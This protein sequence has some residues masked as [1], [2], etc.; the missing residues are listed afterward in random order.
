[1]FVCTAARGVG[2]SS[3]APM[4]AH[5]RLYAS[6]LIRVEA[7]PVLGLVGMMLRMLCVVEVFRMD[8]FTFVYVVYVFSLS[9]CV[10]VCS[11]VCV[12]A[13]VCVILTHETPVR[14]RLSVCFYA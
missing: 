11:V 2:V 14:A 10:C 12:R 9:V 13:C 8:I 1:M 7:Q 6:M 3:S 5:M 4:L